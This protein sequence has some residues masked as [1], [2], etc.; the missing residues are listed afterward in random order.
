L[1]TLSLQ[2]VEQRPS[3]I[4]PQAAR[5]LLLDICTA[6]DRIVAAGEHGIILYSEDD[7]KN[8][9]QASVPTRQ[10]LTGIHFA[11]ARYGWAVGHDGLILFSDDGGVTWRI[12][13][14]GLAVQQQVNIELRELAHHKLAE[15]E[16]QLETAD[17]EARPE[18][19]LAFED[20]QL[21]LEDADIALEEPVFTSAFMDVWFQDSERGWAIGAFGTFV[22]TTDGGQHWV[23]MTGSLDNP[24]EFHLNAITG[25]NKGRVFIAGEGGVM[26]RS[27]DGG[28]NWE[29]LEPFYEG[30]WF[31]SAYQAKNDTLFIFG[32]RGNLYRSTD[33]GT[34]WEMIPNDSNTSLA[35]GSAS[36]GGEVLAVGGVGTL[37]LST[38]GGRSFQRTM[39]E[40]RLSLTSGLVRDGTLIL[41][42]HGGVKVSEVES[43]AR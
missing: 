8:W 37:L 20:A 16:R 3:P 21:D 31:G 39:M 30:S 29:T 17:E 6:G 22:G 36:A 13:R 25:D 41:V 23:D 33:F 27:M 4:V 42:G 24:D 9:Q 1:L 7:G 15:L 40:D 10:M 5:A 2:A 14:D 18:L 11:D 19:E 12:Q 43:R 28:R 26:F 32:L 35:G 34:T 38:D